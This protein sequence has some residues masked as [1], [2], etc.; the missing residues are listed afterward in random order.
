MERDSM[1][2]GLVLSPTSIQE[3][4]GSGKSVRRLVS[5]NGP[6]GVND[7]LRNGLHSTA[8][9]LAPRHPLQT[10]LSTVFFFGKL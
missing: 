8:H 1:T 10:R 3:E 5:E 6:F 7:T 2:A 4:L 9:D